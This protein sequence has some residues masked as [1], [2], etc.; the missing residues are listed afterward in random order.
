MCQPC[1]DTVA[2]R[3]PP[4]PPPGARQRVGNGQT[5]PTS[6]VS[7]NTALCTGGACHDGGAERPARRATLQINTRRAVRHR[8]RP[9]KTPTGS[10]RT[11][12]GGGRQA[13]GGERQRTADGGRRTAGGGRTDGGQRQAGKGTADSERTVGGRQA[14]GGRTADGGRQADEW[15]A[16]GGQQRRTRGAAHV[17]SQDR[18][19]RGRSAVHD[20]TGGPFNPRRRRRRC[21]VFVYAV[22]SALM[23]PQSG[24]AP[25]LKRPLPSAAAPS[26]S[27][28]LQRPWTAASI[29]AEASGRNATAQGGH[30]QL[31]ICD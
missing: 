4:P 8:R 17:P 5:R 29:R 25:G 13:A 30:V 21:G 23:A 27:S 28:G 7:D 15:R 1:P 16:S 3:T 2:T 10:S 24:A 20:V 12:A 22:R 9:T 11:G 14:D 31:H 19:R 6:H 18:E 26:V